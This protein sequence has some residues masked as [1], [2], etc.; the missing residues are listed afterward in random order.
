MIK[1]LIFIA[2]FT[3]SNALEFNFKPTSL[4]EFTIKGFNKNIVYKTKE[5]RDNQIGKLWEKIFSSNDFSIKKSKDKKLYVIYTQYKKN[6]FNCFIG[7]KSN[8]KINNFQEKTIKESK[9]Q[10]GI[11]KYKQSI[12]MSDIWDEIQKE[13]VNRN[14]QVDIEEYSL[15]DLTKDNYDVTIY[16]SSK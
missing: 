6:S 8:Q 5:D 1:I 3:F 9:Y 12:K 11:L 16:L 10:R 2:L 14:F 4:N 15:F 7:I 13:K